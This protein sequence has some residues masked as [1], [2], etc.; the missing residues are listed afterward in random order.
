MSTV[1]KRNISGEDL[2]VAL[3]N[4]QIVKPDEE[5][6]LP[7]HY[8]WHTDDDPAEVV[9]PPSL[10]EDVVQLTTPTGDVVTP[11]ASTSD[12]E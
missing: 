11:T 5:V 9:W 8:E 10:W 4:F 6:D 12:K 1:R 3:L 2:E 7:T